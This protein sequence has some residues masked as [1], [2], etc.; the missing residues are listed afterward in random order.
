MGLYN[1]NYEIASVP[2][3]ALSAP[4]NRALLPGFARIAGDQTAM[5]AAYRNAIGILS[6]IAL[7]AAAGIFAVAPY[8]VPVALGQKWL[9]GVPLME[10][11]AFNG[12]L[13]LIHSSICTALIAVGHPDR[14]V[15]TNAVYVV[16]LLSL[17]VL[18]V[19]RLGLHGAAYAALTASIL[20]TPVYL[21]QVRRTLGIPP[22]G[23]LSRWRS[24]LLLA[25]FSDGPDGPWRS[26]R[27]GRRKW[28]R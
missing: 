14:V 7:P 13:L 6:L 23:S 4:I 20:C 27:S 24:V 28:H 9:A 21:W 1:V 16:M 8:L 5:G 3:T 25:A 18:L 10:I 26:C 15:K 17:L 11:L 19:P 2:T 12:G 22:S